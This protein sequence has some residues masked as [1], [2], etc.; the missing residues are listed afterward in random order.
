MEWRD[1]GT[2]LSVRM[3]G[4]SSAI[5]EVFTAEHGRHA[6]VVRGGASRKVAPILQPGTD[7]AVVWRARLESHIGVFTVEPLLSR[8]GLMGDRRALAALNAICALLRVSLPERAPHGDLWRETGAL[9]DRLTGADWGQHYLNWEVRLLEELGFGLDLVA[10]AV[11]GSTQ[12]L[13]Y[14]SP[15]TGR[16]V[17]R[18]A[19]GEWVDRLFPLPPILQGGGSTEG[20]AEGLAITGHFLGRELATTLGGRPLPEARARLVG[21]LAE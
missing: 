10:C 5:V 4:E 21:M 12:D 14:V 13:A 20:L 15:K 2:I 18:E 19:A 8:S 16:A 7:L 17:S 3:H 11:T 6:G 1:Q 9:L